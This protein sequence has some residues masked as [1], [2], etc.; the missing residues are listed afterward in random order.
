MVPISTDSD[1]LCIYTARS[2]NLAGAFRNMGITVN[3]IN[4]FKKH[5]VKNIH[6]LDGAIRCGELYAYERERGQLTW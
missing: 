6:E 2:F 3:S 1:V 5:V 4:V